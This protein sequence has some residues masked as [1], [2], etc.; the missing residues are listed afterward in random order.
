M[1]STNICTVGVRWNN[2]TKYIAKPSEQTQDISSDEEK[3]GGE[4][5]TVLS[6]L[7]VIATDHFRVNYIRKSPPT[8]SP[9]FW[10]YFGIV[11]FVK[12]FQHKFF[13]ALLVLLWKKSN[14]ILDF[15]LGP[16]NKKPQAWAVQEHEGGMCPCGPHVQGQV[17]GFLYSWS[18]EEL[19]AHTASVF[20]GG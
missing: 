17:L 20:E 11:V 9:G 14:W 10:G 19:N 13:S 18:S 6:A 16:L 7:G 1:W 15:I 4:E 12:C 3:R 5:R 2:Y 8:H